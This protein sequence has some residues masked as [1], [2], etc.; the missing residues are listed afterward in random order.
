MIDIVVHRTLFPRTDPRITKSFK[1]LW[2]SLNKVVP[3]DLWVM[4]INRLRPTEDGT[5]SYV[6]IDVTLS[7]Q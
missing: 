4:T 2:E 3:A 1:T 7:I 6:Q 5:S